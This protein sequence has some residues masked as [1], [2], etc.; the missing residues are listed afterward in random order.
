ML[1]ARVFQDD[2]AASSIQT[3]VPVA[4]FQSSA[5]GLCSQGRSTKKHVSAILSSLHTRLLDYD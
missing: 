1:A 5:Y 2:S 4:P 3:E